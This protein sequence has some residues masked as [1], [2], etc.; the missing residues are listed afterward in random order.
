MGAACAEDA[1]AVDHL[2]V[3]AAVDIGVGMG[4]L[5]NARTTVDG[6]NIGVKVFIA[7]RKVDVDELEVTLRIGVVLQLL[8]K[9]GEETVAGE[10]RPEHGGAVARVDAAAQHVDRQGVAALTVVETDKRLVT[11]GVFHD[12]PLHEEGGHIAAGAVEEAEGLVIIGLVDDV[13]GAGDEGDGVGVGHQLARGGAAH[14]NLVVAVFLQPLG[15]VV[16]GLQLVGEVAL[17]ALAE[18]VA[19]L[20]TVDAVAVAVDQNTHIDGALWVVDGIADGTVGVDGAVAEVATLDA[21]PSG[22]ARGKVVLVKDT[23]DDGDFLPGSVGRELDL[24]GS[25]HQCRAEQ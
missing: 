8:L 5:V 4:V 16:D 7:G 1:D 19:A 11:T 18:G 12:V 25:E 14:L 20:D 2:A 24:A 3:G 17:L 21:H 10:R 15:G 22:V 9:I 13:G 23:V 6:G